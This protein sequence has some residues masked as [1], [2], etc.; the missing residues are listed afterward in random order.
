MSLR[1]YK[2]ILLLT[3]GLVMSAC[4]H[5]NQDND[6]APYYE[7]AYNDHNRAPAGFNPPE[8]AGHSLDSLNQRAQSDYYYAMG[9]AQS[10]EG[11]SQK[12]I[13]SFKMVLV[14]DEGSAQVRTRLAAEYVRMGMV[15][16]ALDQA[17]E[18]SKKDPK[19]IDA[20][21]LLGGLYSSLKSY[22]KAIEQYEEILKLDPKNTDAPMYIGAVYAEQ[23]Q[24]DKA[25]RYFEA[26]A[27]NDDYASPHLA[28]Y[29]MGRIR[30]DQDGKSYKKTAEKFFKKAL[31]V[32]AEH[33]ESVLAL[34]TL[35]M[36][37]GQEDQTLQLYKNFQREHG[38]SVRVAE[39]L[40]QL[41]MEREQY[42]LAYEQL[43]VMERASDEALNVKVKMA[44]ILIEQKAF[45]RAIV[46]LQEILQQ[47]PESDKIRFY[48]AAVYEE[49]GEHFSAVDQFLKIP[50]SSQFYGE[51]VVHAAYILKQKKKIDKALEVVGS[52]LKERKDLPQLYAIHASLLDEKGEYKTAASTLKN[53]VENFP[54]N[55]QLRFFLGTITDHVGTKVEVV[56][57]MKKVV[58][59]DP[60]HVQGLN[61]LAFTYADMGQNLDE[62]EKLVK[63]ALE[64]EPKDAYIIDTHGW[65][66][67]RK[68]QF[69]DAIKVLEA[70]YQLQPNEAVIAEHLGDAYLKVQMSDKARSMY[71]RAAEIEVDERKVK[72][73]RAKISAVEKQEL[74]PQRQPAS[75]SNPNNAK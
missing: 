63:R 30:A 7:A 41:Y 44:L 47:V 21:L 49:M 42:D 24:Y 64:L 62:A 13:E 10:M 68:G 28:Y 50:A 15:T 18:A 23:K 58:E 37:Q 5:L 65:V 57:H 19:Y 75:L 29:Y 72:D 38:P 4:A 3:S 17:L 16:E 46:K 61:Y 11:H 73:I 60:N 32:K 33:V 2:A 69:E 31:S 1:V 26:L 8:N 34:G 54:D 25:V 56:E 74:H 52:S 67:Y 66:L 70:A 55:V 9:E 14:Y 27:K 53:G 59:M 48:L 6:R 20:H 36:E 45:A 51:A 35:Y 71:Q 43:E 12:A 22:K 40:S 39:I